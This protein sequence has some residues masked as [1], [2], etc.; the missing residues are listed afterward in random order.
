MNGWIGDRAMVR[1]FGV[2][3]G[4]LGLHQLEEDFE[5]YLLATNTKAVLLIDVLGIGQPV[6]P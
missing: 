5:E 6:A 4:A 2:L 3:S 1:G